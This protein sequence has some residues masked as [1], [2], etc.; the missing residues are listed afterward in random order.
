MIK[1]RGTRG[2]QK[3]K[4]AKKDEFRNPATEVRGTG[5]GGLHQRKKKIVGTHRGMPERS[6]SE[7]R[8]HE[9]SHPKPGKKRKTGVKSEQAPFSVT[10]QK[11][12]CDPV[13]QKKEEEKEDSA[14]TR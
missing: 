3:E 2:R 6:M 14:I 11:S 9:H 5:D 8:I 13:K 12:Q 4:G 7:V 1:Y 10:F